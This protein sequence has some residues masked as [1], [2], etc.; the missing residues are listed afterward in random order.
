MVQKLFI[1]INEIMLKRGK[2]KNK[3][4]FEF[5]DVIIMYDIPELLHAFF[6]T[7]NNEYNK[8][9]DL[10]I[11]GMWYVRDRLVKEYF[12]TIVWVWFEY[13]RCWVYI[14]KDH[15][16]MIEAERDRRN[17]IRKASLFW[18]NTNGKENN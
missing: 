1:S 5:K 17:N 2:A 12:W 7:D 8:E 6:L 15:L 4:K 10:T 18:T 16:E 11:K 13:K 3:D 14:R 9:V